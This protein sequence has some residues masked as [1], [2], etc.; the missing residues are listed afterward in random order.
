MA[1]LHV[2]ITA[3]IVRGGSAT[4]KYVQR[5]IREQGPEEN[6]LAEGYEAYHNGFAARKM[7][8]EHP[9]LYTADQVFVLIPGKYNA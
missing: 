7:E 2:R 3:Q 5:S 6:T 1:C 9:D 4:R 8:R